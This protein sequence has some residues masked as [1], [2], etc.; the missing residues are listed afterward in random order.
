MIN[1]V[2]NEIFVTGD[3]CT[4][5]TKLFLSFPQRLNKNHE[6]GKFQLPCCSQKESLTQQIVRAVD[7][8]SV[9]NVDKKRKISTSRIKKETELKTKQKRG[10][11]KQNFSEIFAMVK[12][13]PA[14]KQNCNIMIERSF[15]ASDV[16]DEMPSGMSCEEDIHQ[17]TNKPQN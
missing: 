12:F 5:I 4:N 10:F 16:T 11:S 9:S 1:T 13:L 8:L 17:N 15:P 7:Y 2:E 14:Q 6:N 3:F